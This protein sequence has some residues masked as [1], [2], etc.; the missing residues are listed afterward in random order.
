MAC[1]IVAYIRSPRDVSGCYVLVLLCIFAV[2]F[3]NRLVLS[4]P[5]ALACL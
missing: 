5:I 2:Q 1:I 4:V 3:G